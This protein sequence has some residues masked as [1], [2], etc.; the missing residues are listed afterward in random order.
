[1]AGLKAG[2]KNINLELRQKKK[3]SYILQHNLFNNKK[4]KQKTSSKRFAVFAK[5]PV[6]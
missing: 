6:S 1:M 3:G 4:Q 2:K 5:Q